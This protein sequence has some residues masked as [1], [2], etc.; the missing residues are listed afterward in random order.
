MVTNLA[1]CALVGSAL[2]VVRSGGGDAAAAEPGI[3]SA[4]TSTEPTESSPST[5]ADPTTPSQPTTP[6]TSTPPP[7]TPGVPVG[8]Q[9]V[10]GPRGIT[11][12]IPTGWQAK[13][14][15]GQA[16]IQATNPAEP[17]SFLRY[18][19]SPS[20]AE[21]LLAVQQA[22]ERAFRPT[23]AGY[24]L[25]ALT[26]GKWRGHESV[27]W[28]FEFEAAGGRKHVNSTYWRAAGVDYVLYASALVTSW[29]QMKTVYTTALAA[30]KP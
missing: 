9:A 17:T 23:Y 3:T 12:L 19:G 15:E 26:P 6:A 5:T 27:T 18:G 25:I 11:T 30:T 7:T 4:P 2:L 1:V 13:P 29:P 14:R 24:Q 28:E 8:F 16:A 22:A 10:S 20:P 21:P